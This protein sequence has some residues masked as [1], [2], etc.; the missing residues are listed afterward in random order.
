MDL[1]LRW[2]VSGVSLAIFVL[3]VAGLIA[4]GT[5]QASATHVSCGDEIT[6]DTT[7][8]SDLIDCP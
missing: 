8:D 7:L 4:F 1:A 5:S 3:G 6:A 2:A